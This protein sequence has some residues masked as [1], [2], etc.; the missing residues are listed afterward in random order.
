MDSQ[1]FQDISEVD[2]ADLQRDF[3]PSKHAGNEVYVKLR[4]KGNRG[5]HSWKAAEKSSSPNKPSGKKH[6]QTSRLSKEKEGLLAEVKMAVK[7]FEKEANAKVGQQ[8]KENFQIKLALKRVEEDLERKKQQWE[9]ERS[10]LLAWQQE[11]LV[12]AVEHAQQV[13]MNERHH[14]Q[15]MATQLAWQ[16]RESACLSAALNQAR[17]DLSN[18][19][20]LWEEEKS[21]LLAQHQEEVSGL[22]ADLEQA[23]KDLMSERNKW[24]EEKAS[25][26]RNSEEQRGT[27][28]VEGRTPK[29]L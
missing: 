11:G 18:Q 29:Q 25:L 12:A 21:S 7:N 6:K 4:K 24:R 28:P 26:E 27:D 20:K 19:T 23:K 13:L 14:W 15:C 5:A 10:S 9:V 16:E 17:K 22:V 2:C 3:S 1:V 8:K